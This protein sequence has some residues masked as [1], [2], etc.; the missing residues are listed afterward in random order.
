MTIKYQPSSSETLRNKN[1]ITESHM[2]MELQYAHQCILFVNVRLTMTNTSS[3]QDMILRN[4]TI[5]WLLL[6]YFL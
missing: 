6:T 3:K 1:Q 5:S 4:K 2:A